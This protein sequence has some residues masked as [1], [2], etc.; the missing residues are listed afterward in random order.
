MEGSGGAER[1]EKSVVVVVVRRRVF[2]VRWVVREVW[3]VIRLV[4]RWSVHLL[5]AFFEDTGREERG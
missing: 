1:G 2:C 3:V 5:R 4:V